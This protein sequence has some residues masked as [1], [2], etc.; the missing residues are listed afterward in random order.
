MDLKVLLPFGVFSAN[1]GVAR[2]VAETRE[3]SYGILPRRLDCVATLVP[4]ILMYQCESQAEVY[5]A[6][7]EG[8][9][10]KCGRQVLVSV[11]RALGGTGLAEL[12]AAVAAE[13]L[14]LNTQEQQLH[15]AL[16]KIES[17]FISRLA[18]LHH[19]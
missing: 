7:D 13:F 17:G 19:G 1:T 18:A 12:R 15:S 6:V 2:I 3:G 5:V 14:A 8:V 4:G 9:L 10:I 16:L 11:R